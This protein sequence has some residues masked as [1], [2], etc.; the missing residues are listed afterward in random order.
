MSFEWQII[1]WVLAGIL[2]R[3]VVPYL[4][5]LKDGTLPFEPK[6]LVSPLISVLISLLMSPLLFAAMP[7]DLAGPWAAFVFGWFESD[8]IRE[9]LR[10]IEQK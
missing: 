6:Y 4:I 10:L 2:A 3:T 5:K 1:V 8:A 9:L 7:A